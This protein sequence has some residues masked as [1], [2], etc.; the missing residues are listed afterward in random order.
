MWCACHGVPPFRV[1]A[2][3]GPAH[4]TRVSRPTNTNVTAI[5][6]FAI[7]QGHPAG[8]GHDDRDD[9]RPARLAPRRVLAGGARPLEDHRHAH[10]DVARDHHPVVDGLA[11]VDRLEHRRQAER[12]HDHPDHLH[13]RRQPVDPVVGVV[14]RGEPREVDPRPD[15]REASRG[16]SRAGRPG[17]APRPRSARAR[18]PRSRRRRRTSGRTAA[19]AAWRCGGPRAGRARPSGSGGAGASRSR[20]HGV[21]EKSHARPR[22]D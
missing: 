19:R 4:S 13:H 8:L 20:R 11:L 10:D 7:E 2:I 18:P 15:D 6:V 22:A 9:V 12:E 1:S 21:I 17:S 14:G 5:D 16:R 3:H